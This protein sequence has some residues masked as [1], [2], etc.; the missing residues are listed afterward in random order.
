MR[1]PACS[2][3]KEEEFD[4]G[5]Q[6]NGNG[7]E[8]ELHPHAQ[9][10]EQQQQQEGEQGQQAAAVGRREPTQVDLNDVEGATTEMWRYI[11]TGAGLMEGLEARQALQDWLDLLAAHHPVPRW[12]PGWMGWGWL[13]WDLC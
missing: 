4:S 8:A 11:V 7:A 5:A 13:E 6:G 1:H 3:L 2:K 9:Q 10:Q 12:A